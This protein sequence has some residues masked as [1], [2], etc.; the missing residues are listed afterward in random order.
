M[1]I[2][3]RDGAG[4]PFGEWLRNNRELDS[5]NHQVAATDV[6]MWIHKYSPRA[7]RRRPEN[8]LDFLDL[9]MLVEI[10]TFNAEPS[11]AQR[12][13]L[14]IVEQ[15][16][17]KPSVR[18]NART[19]PRRYTVQLTET[20]ISHLMQ[21][22]RP[23]RWYGIHVLQLSTDRPD[24]SSVI[25]WDKKQISEDR[26]VGLLRFDFDPDYP[27]RRIDTRRHHVVHSIAEVLPLLKLIE[28][29]R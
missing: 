2:I 13:T 10:K 5:V 18:K 11:Y 26:L 8:V 17:R 9:L 6:D 22:K 3:R 25:L 23:M 1:T 24:T 28:G 20:R 19:G 4:A 12:D 29:G 21:T 27:S 16:M 7:E 15:Y 14:G